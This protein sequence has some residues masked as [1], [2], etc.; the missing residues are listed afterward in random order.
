MPRN[1]S[2]SADSGS[3]TAN[4]AADVPCKIHLL[5]VGPDKYGDCF[6]CQLADK[7]ILIDGSHPADHMPRSGHRSI[8]QQLVALLGASPIHL[9]LLVVTHAH[10][11]HIGCLPKLVR[12][13][14]ITAQWA[15]LADP[16][17][18]WGRSQ[19]PDFG[20]YPDEADVLGAVVRE[21]DRSD[22]RDA[23]LEQFFSDAVSLEANYNAMIA[24]L[25]QA[26]TSVVLYGRDSTQALEAAFASVGLTIVGPTAAHLKICSDAIAQ[27]GRDTQDGIRAQLDA[28]SNIIA[29]YRALMAGDSGNVNAAINN[30]SIVL[31]FQLG[32][33]KLLF[34]GD[35]QLASAETQ[36]L[37]AEMAT[38]LEKIKGAAPYTFVKIGHH[39]SYNALNLQVLDAMG[40]TPFYGIS[41]G[42]K[43]SSHPSIQAL[44]ALKSQSSHIKWARTD[45]NRLITFD[46]SG[47]Q[48][49]IALEQGTINDA[50]PNPRDEIETRAPIVPTP[51][52]APAVPPA[53]QTPSSASALSA[54]T[55][56]VPVASP[57]G[58]SQEQQWVEVTARVP[59]TSTRLT[60][61]IE[62]QPGMAPTVNKTD[63]I[64]PQM[65]STPPINLA[66]GRQLP[67]LLFVTDK[68]R[69]ET[70]IGALECQ[71][72]LQCLQG[73]GHTVIDTIPN[74]LDALRASEAVRATLNSDNKLRGVVIVGGYDVVPALRLDVL[75]AELRS[76]LGSNGDPDDFKVW[77][78]AVYGDIDGDSLPDLPVSRIP[79]GK[80]AVLVQAALEANAPLSTNNSKRCGVRNIARPFAETIYDLV[81]GTQALLSSAPSSYNQQPQIMLDG[82]RVY[83]MLHGAWQDGSRFWGEQVPN[84]TEAVHISNLPTSFRGVVF[85][86]CCWGALISQKP[87]AR[88][89]VNEVVAAKTADT[90]IAL[91]FL[92]R[93]AQAFIGCT[94]VHYS[95]TVEPFDYFGGP[96]HAAFWK[97]HRS[98]KAPAEALLAAK[99][100]YIRAMPHGQTTP[101][102][103]AVEYKILRQYTC[104][105][106][107]W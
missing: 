85:T 2:T 86:G 13:G 103:Q 96:M 26:G 39:A 35:M 33:R 22:V 19:A 74:A 100:D 53:V 1:P 6:V 105:G 31:G 28:Q 84:G 58:Q 82:E 92:A 93:G 91:A 61:T 44:E 42:E 40:A 65:P 18:G 70:N 83:L 68:A 89:P 75:P 25:Q 60:L 76:Q 36:G 29:T 102:L 38:L 45:H 49:R 21:E 90:S 4:A 47:S 50:T 104:L 106:L 51:P 14:V 11:D 23:A 77:S 17:L 7:T 79:D 67:P 20:G 73:K 9:D 54:S 78:D 80:S 99:L 97:H 57:H 10:S 5:D 48:P 94:G 27:L 12:D 101:A 55:S 98:G 88:T 81:P 16:L 30:Q 87:A 3:V 107:G 8:P 63:E 66:A 24:Q 95:P 43:S 41:T 46:F 72:V 62:V 64:T 15:L 69:L 56:A 52:V 32:K 37:Q 59:H 71:A 34:T